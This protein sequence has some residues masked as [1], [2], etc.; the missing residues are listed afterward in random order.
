VKSSE[1]WSL[2]GKEPPASDAAADRSLAA[3]LHEV[4]NTLTVVLGWL[5]GALSGLAP[6]AER[7]A[8]EV[9]LAH[10]RLGYRIARRAIGAD[11]SDLERER[12][13]AAIAHDATLALMHEARRRGV[14]LR[15]ADGSGGAELVSEAA[16]VLQILLNL[17]L[18]ALAFSP[19][20]STVTVRLGHQDGYVLF[21][22]EDR[23][24]GIAPERAERLLTGPESTRHGGAGI[25]L[26]H[27]ASLAE[28]CGGSLRLVRSIGG[29]TFALRWPVA[30][31]RTDSRPPS[32]PAP[33]LRGTRVLVVEDDAAVLSLIELA[34]GARGAEV[35]GARS[36]DEVSLALD[37][38]RA[39][40]AALV[41][42][43]PLADRACEILSELSGSSRVPVVLIS[44]QASGV[45][46]EL[47]HHVRAWVRKPFE[48]GE[49]VDVL[50]DVMSDRR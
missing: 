46:E 25:G 38:G 27:S 39:L 6:G 43:S 19:E 47:E 20:G 32:G 17:L 7:Q 26:R 36:A 9:A 50:R 22:V 2:A 33:A 10:A 14:E 13:A 3:A 21:E 40:S 41:D 8:I 29:A 4:S 5:D 18:N 34:L 48:M 49:I 23:G 16:S 15:F 45:P 42:L 44:G 35:V 1:A 11:V 30:E 31:L 28:A 24:P 37:S 12:P